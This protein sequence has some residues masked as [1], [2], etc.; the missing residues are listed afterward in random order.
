MRSDEF[1]NFYNTIKPQLAARVG[2]LTRTFEMLDAIDRPVGIVET[3]CC[4]QAGNWAGDGGSTLLFDKYVQCHP[5]SVVY[6]VD[7]DPAATALCRSLV[8]AHVKVHTGDSV[9]FLKTLADSPPA[10]LPA[11]DLLYLD[12]YDVNFDDVFPSAF[13]HMKELVAIAPLVQAH[14]LVVVDDSPSAFTGFINAEGQV[15]LVT[16]P[17]TGGKGKLVGEY[18]QHIGAEKVFDGYQCGWIRMRG[19]SAA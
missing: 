7:I 10:D 15:L 9:A 12:S 4:R 19:A 2:T 5:G 13:H 18:A 6:T 3:G 8:S 1:W 17:K 11:L 16:P 14:T